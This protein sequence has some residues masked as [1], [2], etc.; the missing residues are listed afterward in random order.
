MTTEKRTTIL[1]PSVGESHDECHFMS[2]VAQ[3]FSADSHD[4]DS[5]FTL[6]R[7][8]QR[9]LEGQGQLHKEVTEV[10]AD[11]AELKLEQRDGRGREGSGDR[12]HR[13]L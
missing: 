12:A 7:T 11:K 8:G 9:R 3:G 5:S 2:G 4:S 1:R 13:G 6:A 10:T